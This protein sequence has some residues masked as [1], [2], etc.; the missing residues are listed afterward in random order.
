[1]LVTSKV[2]EVVGFIYLDKDEYNNNNINN[3]R[4]FHEPVEISFCT[5]Q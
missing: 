4:Y 2:C 3:M 5:S 1:M